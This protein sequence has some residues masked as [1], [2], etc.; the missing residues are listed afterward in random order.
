MSSIDEPTLRALTD[1]LF[2]A[3]L[4]AMSA[5]DSPAQPPFPLGPDPA[6]ASYYTRRP[7]AAMARADFL[8]PSCLDA[9][10]FAARLAAYWQAAGRPALA[11]QAPRVAETAR[12]LQALYQQA[13]PQAEVSPYI[14]QMF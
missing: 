11:Q 3:L 14:Y 5:A 4:D 12:A 13:R 8:A 10:E 1:P 2:D 6:L 7:Q 9:G